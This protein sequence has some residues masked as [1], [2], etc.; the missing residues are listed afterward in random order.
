MAIKIACDGCDH[1]VPL[2]PKHP[3]HVEPEVAGLG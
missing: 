2:H 3:E 1:A